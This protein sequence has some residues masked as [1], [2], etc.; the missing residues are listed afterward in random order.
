MSEMTTIERDEV[1]AWREA[2]PEAALA[3]AIS[4]AI[5]CILTFEPNE[6]L[7]KQAVT[8]LMDCHRRALTAFAQPAPRL[9]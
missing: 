5:G 3:E 2:H 9:H 1:E 8:V 4:A 7:R 6:E